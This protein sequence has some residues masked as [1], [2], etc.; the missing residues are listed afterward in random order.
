MSM[1]RWRRSAPG[2]ECEVP[3]VPT[4]EEAMK[5]LHYAALSA[6]IGLA[7][8]PAFS[9]PAAAQEPKLILIRMTPYELG[10]HG[11]AVRELRMPPFP[12]SCRVA[13]NPRLSVSNEFLAH[14]QGRGFSLESLCLGISSHIH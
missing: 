12:N 7:A 10:Q 14:F 13:G 4:M 1:S 8:I 2:G 6:A 3:D 5:A 9:H 11:I